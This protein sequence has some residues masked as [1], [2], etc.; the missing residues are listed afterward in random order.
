MDDALNP[1]ITN[2]KQRRFLLSFAETG[3]VVE[4]ARLAGI[5]RRTHYRWLESD[6]EYAREFDRAKRQGGDIVESELYRRAVQGVRELELHKGKPVR[7]P[8][9][10]GFLYKI[11][12]S[13]ALLVV[14]LR[15]LIP[16]KYRDNH[17]QVPEDDGVRI[18]GRKRADV[19]R[20][21]IEA[22]Q[23]ALEMIVAAEGQ[24]KN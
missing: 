15:A 2:P 9:T 10:G 24:Q 22:R 12:Y 19:I 11:K 16:E 1:S 3:N 18:A 14:L 20:E 6:P 7:D 21:E 17:P 8:E 13:D 4:S 5:Q 23:K